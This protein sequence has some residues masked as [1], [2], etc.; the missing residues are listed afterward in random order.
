MISLRASSSL[1]ALTVLLL[2][3]VLAQAPAAGNHTAIDK[4]FDAF[5]KADDAKD[6]AKAADRLV[7]TGI[8]FDVAWAR[9]KAGRTYAKE[10]TG[11]QTMRR[12][13]GLGTIFE[14]RIEVPADYDPARPWSL[15]VQLHGGVNRPAT[16]V[17]S[18]PDIEGEPSNRQGGSGSRAPNLAR[19]STVNRVPGDS[20]IYFYPSGWV[21]AQW[22]HATQIDNILTV[23]DTLKRR[24]NVDE[25][26]IYLTG[27]S[28]GGTGAYF[29]AM[30]ETTM[31]SSFL[32]LNGSILVLG[33]PDVRADGEI[34]ANNLVNKPLYI[35]NGGRDPLYPVAN[36]ETHIAWFK[37]LG[38][39]FVFNPQPNAGHDTSWWPYVRGPFERFVQ[40]HP[41]QPHPEKLSWETDRTDRY[42]RAHW[43]VIDA[44]GSTSSDAS[45]LP[46][47][48]FGGQADSGYFKHRVAS[49][50][51]DIE[52]HGNA[53]EARTRG[54]REFRLLLSPDVI[55][56]AKPVTVSVNGKRLFDGAV[57]KDPAVL[58]AWAA[59]DNDRTMLY[60]AEL[61]IGA[62]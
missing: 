60:G 30:K 7:K 4:A 18:G 28:D 40:E 47:E 57:K 38:V 29:I 26:H 6:A 24:Y 45:N 3:R 1:V 49:G 31:W 25:S 61:R 39:P 35:V 36:V 13:A 62:Q 42:N 32:P 11:A 56:F 48:G 12:S 54:V 16:P 46:P 15:R 53:F 50:R 55:D 51:V 5:W 19:R 17:P 8:D 58:L 34:F 41:R 37:N 2:A 22:W 20:Q 14:N 52:R 10:K 27:I 59:K 21:D 33:N 43:L 9:L 23:V 44:L